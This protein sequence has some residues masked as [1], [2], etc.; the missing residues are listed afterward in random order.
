MLEKKPLDKIQRTKELIQ[1]IE[2]FHFTGNFDD[3]FFTE[4][5]EK[6]YV[7]SCEKVFIQMVCG[8]KITETIS[9]KGRCK[10]ENS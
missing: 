5:V 2:E 7:E 3:T 9:I 1:S 10:G 6:I 4:T 8:L